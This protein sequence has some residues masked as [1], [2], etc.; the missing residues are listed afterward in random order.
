MHSEDRHPEINFFLEAGGILPAESEHASLKRWILDTIAS[1]GA[2]AGTI[3]YIFCGDDYLLKINQQYLDHDYY[4]DI[5]TFPSA[6]F[7]EVSGD[8]FISTDR[9]NDNTHIYATD[10]QEELRR[11]IIHGI[12]HLCGQGDKTDEEAEQMRAKEN[13]A[14][15]SYV[16]R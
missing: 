5:I 1:Y 9:V 6:S 12:L 15:A 4:T 14:L 3:N 7:P 8:I 10:Y 2:Q 11:V 13:E 16:V